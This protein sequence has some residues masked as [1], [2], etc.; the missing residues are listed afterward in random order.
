MTT[1]AQA[2][3]KA[4]RDLLHFASVYLVSRHFSTVAAV[5][6][7]RKSRAAAKTWRGSVSD[8]ISLPSHRDGLQL[9][10][11]GFGLSP[12]ANRKTLASR[13]SSYIVAA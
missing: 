6:D 4:L 7:R 10:R 12:A 9:E 8:V 3:N 5:Y 13:G 11:S 1:F 2:L